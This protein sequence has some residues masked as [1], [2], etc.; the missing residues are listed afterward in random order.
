MEHTITFN[1]FT[2]AREYHT[3]AQA[4]VA[5]HLS[6]MVEPV[7]MLLPEDTEYCV[8]YYDDDESTQHRCVVDPTSPIQ[9]GRSR[10][11][12]KAGKQT[13]GLIPDFATVVYN[14]VTITNDLDA[15]CRL[16]YSEMHDVLTIMAIQMPRRFK[17]VSS[18]YTRTVKSPSTIVQAAIDYIRDRIRWGLAGVSLS[19]DPDYTALRVRN[20]SLRTVIA[21]VRSST[22]GRVETATNDAHTPRALMM[23]YEM[24]SK[25]FKNVR[26]YYSAMKQLIAMD[27]T[28]NWIEPA[29]MVT[30]VRLDHYKT[31]L[32]PGRGGNYSCDKEHPDAVLWHSYRRRINEVVNFTTVI[33]GGKVITDNIETVK[34]LNMVDLH[35]VLVLLLTGV[36]TAFSSIQGHRFPA[37]QDALIVI[38]YLR[39]QVQGMSANDLRDH[40]GHKQ[41]CEALAAENRELEAKVDAIMLVLGEV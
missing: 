11:T 10:S 20:M 19:T 4:F 30:V 2:A 39:T 7:S 41:T 38:D 1:A 28:H 29:S 16:T 32:I 36:P 31:K 22:C 3:T 33:Y 14:G 8:E 37:P 17:H 12:F 23:A 40:C 13:I 9:Q 6:G 21:N 35:T 25:V 34:G 27:T 24:V 5:V 18:S 26:D 15:I